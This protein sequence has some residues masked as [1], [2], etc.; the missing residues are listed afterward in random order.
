MWVLR[1]RG[2]MLHGWEEESVDHVGRATRY[3]G[4]KD[5]MRDFVIV[6]LN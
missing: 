1:L 5:G 2:T 6:E 3:D 4:I